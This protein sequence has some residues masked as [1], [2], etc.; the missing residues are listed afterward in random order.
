VGNF[1]DVLTEVQQAGSTFDLLR[2]RYLEALSDQTG[3]NVILYYSGWLQK[4]QLVRQDSIGFSVSDADKNGF[5]S[6]VHRLD[7]SRGLDLV[8]H[9]PGGDVAATESIVDYL[10]AM[11]GGNVRAIVPELAMSAGTMIALSCNQVIM[12]SHSSLGPIDPQINGVPAHGV[13]EEFQTALNDVRNDPSTLGIWQPIIAKYSPTLI[14]ECQKAIQWANNIV[15]AWLVSG[16]FAGQDDAATRAKTIVD[17]LGDHAATLS[18]ARHY[19]ADKVESLGVNVGRLEQ[20]PEL[21]DAVL[22]VHHLAMLTLG[23]TPAIKIIENHQG[24]AQIASA[25]L[26]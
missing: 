21:Q 18:H 25:Q 13:V 20:D 17:E 8:L 16:M 22:T 4:P 7:R 2:R 9:T 11:F 26:Q 19:S 15:N 3:R 12:G 23:S 1:N 10:R 6:A 5:M 14:G 24:T